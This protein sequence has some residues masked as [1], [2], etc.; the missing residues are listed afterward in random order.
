MVATKTALVLSLC[1][2]IVGASLENSITKNPTLQA[3]SL[4]TAE[5]S[6]LANFLSPGPASNSSQS[7]DM[8]SAAMEAAI[9]DLMLGKTSF[10]ATPM[11]GSVKKN[12]KSSHQGYD[13]KGFGRA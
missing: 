13:A 9:T 8:T 12:Q 11:G 10:G 3:G 2:V 5:A 1:L 7:V 4:G 6:P